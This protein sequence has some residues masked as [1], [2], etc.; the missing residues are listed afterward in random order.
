[1]LN[2]LQDPS[3]PQGQSTCSS[4]KFPVSW[5]R[6]ENTRHAYDIVS[7]INFSQDEYLYYEDVAEVPSLFL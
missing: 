3:T 6:L 1:M 5:Y 4:R 2:H 7:S